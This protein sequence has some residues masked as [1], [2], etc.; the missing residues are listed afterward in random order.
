MYR[1]LVVDDEEDARRTVKRRLEHQG[2]AVDT[3]ESAE[4]GI[5]MIQSAPEPY[6][7]VVTDMSMEDPE[8]GIRILQ[9]AFGRDVFAEVIVM[10]AY[11]NVK[12][13]VECLKRGAFDYIEKNIPGV[14]VYE[15]ITIKVEQALQRR[16]QNLRAI[17]EWETTRTT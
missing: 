7:V 2:F 1:I 15:I 13:A 3:A 10:T 6:D 12:N 17:R 14:D 8:A 5:E 16:R 11:G 9:A 4:E